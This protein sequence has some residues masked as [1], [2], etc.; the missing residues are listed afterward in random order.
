MRSSSGE[1]TVHKSPRQLAD[2]ESRQPAELTLVGI[3]ASAGGLE[4]LE[5]FFH[6]MPADSG[7]A[8]VLV[9][10]LD[11]TH[12][13]HLIELLARH[14]RMPVA[15][16]SSGM[17]VQAN[18]VYVIPPAAYLTISDKT[19]HLSEPVR[20]RGLRLPIDFFF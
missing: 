15:E 19:L 16:V 17:R 8:F 11:P 13:S 5:N 6:A 18:H 2:G 1:A 4:A 14:T 10:H 9:M 20:R 7:M 12:E 3:G